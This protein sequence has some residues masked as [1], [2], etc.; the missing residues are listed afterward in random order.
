MHRDLRIKLQ[1][2]MLEVLLLAYCS[3]TSL[4]MGFVGN[5]AAQGFLRFSTEHMCTCSGT[6]L[7]A[8]ALAKSLKRGRTSQAA[9]D[10]EHPKLGG[11]CAPGFKQEQQPS[12][13]EDDDEER[14]D[15]ARKPAHLCKTL[16]KQELI[17]VGQASR[18]SSKRK[19]K[20]AAQ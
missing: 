16:T 2:S 12:S 9:K 14:P 18:G 15:A 5:V 11:E 10:G 4:L 19:R 1:A 7:P 17:G 13:D 6:T 3:F 20:R 8:S